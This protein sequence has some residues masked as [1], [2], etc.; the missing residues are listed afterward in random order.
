MRLKDKVCVVT[1]AGLGAMGHAIAL[2]MAREGASLV[3]ADID[4]RRLDGTVSDLRESGAH[5]AGVPTDM[6]EEEAVRTL[7][8]TAVD[9]FERIDVLVN[10][11]GVISRKSVEDCPLDEWRNVF[12][13]NVESVFLAVK[14]AVPVMRAGGGGAIVNMSSSAALVA[15]P[16]RPAY[17]ASKGAIVSLTRQLAV[18]LAKD[19]IRVNAIAPSSVEDTGMYQ[20][21]PDVMRDAEEV[22][23]SLF[24]THALFKG[25]GRIA[26]ADDIGRAVA[27]LASDDAAMITGVTLSVD[28]GATAV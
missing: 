6:R 15:A 4:A 18:D 3:V 10:N 12:R 19:R 2:A 27:F 23:Q 13:S 9:R 17:C 24:A 21:R 8:A 5:A 14:Y 16:D 1:G 25:L 7:L 26:R 22:K 20:S 28:G 11:V